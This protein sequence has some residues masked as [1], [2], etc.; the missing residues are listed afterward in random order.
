MLNTREAAR[1]LRVSQATVRRWFDAGLLPGYRI[2]RRKERRFSEADLHAFMEQ[3]TPGATGA[4][5]VHVGGFEVR[6]PAHF[7]A[8]SGSDAGA[9]RVTAP[10]LADGVRLRQ[11]TFL[12]ASGPMLEAYAKV[13]DLEAVHVVR[14]EGGAAADAIAHWE[15]IFALALADGPTVIRIVGEMA[16]ERPM[17]SSEDEM[18]RYEEAFETM[19]RRYPAVTICQ[20]DVRHFDGVALLRALKAHPDVFQFRTG[21]LFN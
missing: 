5:G 1:L 15:G 12:V 6:P 17:F 4:R 3:S 19:S 20:Y 2:G 8:F 14:F 10:F 16:E 18:L 7:A 21:T 11:P 13:V 9:V